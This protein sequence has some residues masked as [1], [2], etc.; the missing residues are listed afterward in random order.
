V[1]DRSY[2]LQAAAGLRALHGVRDRAAYA[3]ALIAPSP[4]YVRARDGGY[5]R[6]LQ[7]GVRLSGRALR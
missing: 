1:G 5:W 7:R 2:G 6:R 4:E 3:R